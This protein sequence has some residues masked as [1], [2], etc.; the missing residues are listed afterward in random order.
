MLDLA[1]LADAESFV[2]FFAMLF[3]ADVESLSDDQLVHAYTLMQYQ[4]D[5]A[6]SVMGER[7]LITEHMGAAVVP[8]DPP[9]GLDTPPTVL[10]GLQELP[11]SP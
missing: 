3:G 6:L 8:Y 7:G 11:P 9:A 4:A 1:T 5:R 2:T 10:N